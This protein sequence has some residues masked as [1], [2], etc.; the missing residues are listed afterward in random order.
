MLRRVLL[1]LLAASCAL[2]QHL[3][4][5]APEWK[6][7]APGGKP[8]A[9]S[10]YTGKAV[11]LAFI[12]TSC[13]HCRQTVGY[14]AKDQQKYGPRGF[15]VLAS[16]GDPGVPGVI[17]PF[18]KELQLPFP[19]GY[20]TDGNAMLAFMGYDRRH[21]PHYPILLFIDRQGVIRE[22]HEG[23]EQKDYFND[24]QEQNLQ[25]SIEASLQR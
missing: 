13:S 10:Q 7:D 25:K 20:N 18:I 6:I 12:L 15:Q 22:Q 14:L 8:I 24:R 5:K 11:L 9:L 1:V 21:L 19:V 17:P 2:A 16:A 4:R 3:P 23:I